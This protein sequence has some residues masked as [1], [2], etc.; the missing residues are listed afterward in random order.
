MSKTWWFARVRDTN[1]VELFV[2]KAS[3]GEIEYVFANPDQG[4]KNVDVSQQPEG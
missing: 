4:N 3:E 2:D 1:A